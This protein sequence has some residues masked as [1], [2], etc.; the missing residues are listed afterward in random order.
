ML[1]ETSLVLSYKH[2]QQPYREVFLF[3]FL[4]YVAFHRLKDRDQVVGRNLALLLLVERVKCLIELGELLFGQQIGLF[5]GNDESIHT[6]PW[7]ALPKVKYVQK[8]ARLLLAHPRSTERDTYRRGAHHFGPL[9]ELP[10]RDDLS[11][12]GQ[13]KR[14]F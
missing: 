14:F 7:Q 2:K 4:R 13:S 9:D 3:L 10:V 12:R 11:V 1:R 8:C 6:G 5:M